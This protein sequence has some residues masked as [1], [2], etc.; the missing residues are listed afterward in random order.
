LDLYPIFLCDTPFT[1][2]FVRLGPF[3][4]EK[5]NLSLKH[6]TQK[7]SNLQNN[8]RDG[9][10]SVKCFENRGRRSILESIRNSSRDWDLRVQTHRW[11]GYDQ[12]KAITGVAE[13]LIGLFRVVVDRPFCR[14]MDAMLVKSTGLSGLWVKL[15]LN[16]GRQYG[17]SFRKRSL[18]SGQIRASLTECMRGSY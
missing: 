13:Q 12:H 17:I 5:L 1:V 15:P 6:V 14:P 11:M 9:I 7:D 3:L 10:Y 4:E 16:A 18:P 8:F 2:L